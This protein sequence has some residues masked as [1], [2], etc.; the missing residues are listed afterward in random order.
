MK[1]NQN[2]IVEFINS[3]KGYEGYVQFSNGPIKDI[4]TTK[5]DISVY[6]EKGAFV[7]EAHFFNGLESLAIKQVNDSWLVSKTDVSNIDEKDT[8]T[9]HAYEKNVKMGQIWQ[10]EPDELCEGMMVKKLKKVVFLGF[11][12]G[13]R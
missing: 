13:E 10:E 5:S 4:F 6:A 11:V 3:L 7:Y 2:E 8:I 9:Y 1:K 12:G